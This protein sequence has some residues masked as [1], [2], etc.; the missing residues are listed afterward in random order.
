MRALDFIH[1]L[2]G[3]A[4]TTSS[5]DTGRG[6]A[7]ARLA[8]KREANERIPNGERITRQRMRQAD[9][10]LKKRSR[11]ASMPRYGRVY[12]GPSTRPSWRAYDAAT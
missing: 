4:P 11:I 6:R 10:L 5:L 8:A 3:F 12:G 2:M 1:R 9:R 7:A